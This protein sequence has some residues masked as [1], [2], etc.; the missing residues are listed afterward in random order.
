MATPRTHGSR[1]MTGHRGIVYRPDYHADPLPVCMYT[2]DPAR[3]LTIPFAGLGFSDLIE[4]GPGNLLFTSRYYAEDEPTDENIRCITVYNRAGQ[5]QRR[6]GTCEQVRGVRFILYLP[7]DAHHEQELVL[8]VCEREGGC[9]V[10]FFTVD[11]E[12]VRTSPVLLSNVNGIVYQ[13]GLFFALCDTGD[14]A[15]IVFNWQDEVV[16]QWGGLADDDVTDEV[17]HEPS[18]VLYYPKQLCLG[19]NPGE[20]LVVTE[21]DTPQVLLV[22]YREGVC[23]LM[24]IIALPGVEALT[25]CVACNR[26]HIFYTDAHHEELLR[27]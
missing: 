18:P 1:L 8:V 17:L 13:A 11:G 14:H 10:K 5:V 24:D 19:V 6:F 23:R 4:D 2:T 22:R 26:G 20:L 12:Y 9:C 16:T 21:S 3:P 7:A 27:L 25:L 15:L